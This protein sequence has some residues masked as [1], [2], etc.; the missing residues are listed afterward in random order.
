MAETMFNDTIKDTLGRAEALEG[1]EK[2]VTMR[3]GSLATTGADCFKTLVDRQEEAQHLLNA[4]V[5]TSEHGGPSSHSRT[6]RLHCDG[7]FLWRC[8]SRSDFST[9][10]TVCVNSFLKDGSFGKNAGWAAGRG[11][12][13]LHMCVPEIL[14]MR[15]TAQ[16]WNDACM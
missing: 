10:R 3:A 1:H 5:S 8:R 12:C 9:L 16:V 4:L 11:H 14:Q 2:T 13:G 15:V 7:E 6:S